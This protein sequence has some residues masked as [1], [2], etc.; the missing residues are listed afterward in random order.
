MLELLL[1]AVVVV[2]ALEVGILWMLVAPSGVRKDDRPAGLRGIPESI[3]VPAKKTHGTLP[4]GTYEIVAGTSPGEPVLP[5]GV[6]VL[7]TKSDEVWVF[8]IWAR[9]D[10]GWVQLQP[11]PGRGAFRNSLVAGVR[12]SAF[13]LWLAR[14][15]EEPDERAVREAAG[16]L[17]PAALLLTRARS[18]TAPAAPVRALSPTPSQEGRTRPEVGNPIDE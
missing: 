6:V 3:D 16:L 8:E 14:A 13:R 10:H 9:T 2:I 15:G 4:G 7:D 5:S 18:T 17:V 1:L 11:G 12:L